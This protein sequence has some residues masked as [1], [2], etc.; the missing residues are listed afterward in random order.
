MSDNGRCF[1]GRYKGSHP[2]LIEIISDLEGEEIV[3]DAAN[4]EF[5]L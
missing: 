2:M 3:G 4:S 5:W 1:K